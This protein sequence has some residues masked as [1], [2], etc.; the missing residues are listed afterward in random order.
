MRK[1]AERA[2][3]R[4]AWRLLRVALKRLGVPWYL[5]PVAWVSRKFLARVM[6]KR[7]LTW[8]DIYRVI[9]DW[10]GQGPM[11]EADEARTD[12]PV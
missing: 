6:R 8:P 2:A 1:L 11:G 10:L 9:W 7:N 12:P 4:I 5:W 3:G